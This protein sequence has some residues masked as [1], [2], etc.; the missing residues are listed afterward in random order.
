MTAVEI[1]FFGNTDVFYRM[2]PLVGNGGLCSMSQVC[3]VWNRNIQNWI[4]ALHQNAQLRVEGRCSLKSLVVLS[5]TGGCNL[6]DRWAKYVGEPIG[7]DPVVPQAYIEDMTKSDPDSLG[8][9]KYQTH[10]AVCKY[11]AVKRPICE[12]EIAM[13][14]EKGR[15]R[16]NPPEFVGIDSDILNMWAAASNCKAAVGPSKIVVGI[17]IWNMIELLRHPLAGKENGPVI[18]GIFSEIFKQCYACETAP[19]LEFVKRGVPQNSRSKTWEQQ[20]NRLPNTKVAGILPL[21]I[22]CGFDI[23]EIKNCA[24]GDTP[25]GWLTYARTP[26]T[27]QADGMSLHLILGGFAPGAGVYVYYSYYDLGDDVFG[28]VPG[29]PA[30]V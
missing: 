26:D 15:L 27:M 18:R 6:R 2:L 22:Q 5:S 24:Y 10:G 23:L 20:M 8:L 1:P 9:K 12:G 19:S 21:L 28:A 7:E 4:E 17:S 3:N 13:V 30:E 25:N 29:G 14:D 11:T 16:I